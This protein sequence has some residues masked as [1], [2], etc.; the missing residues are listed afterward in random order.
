MSEDKSHDVHIHRST[1]AI[2]TRLRPTLDEMEDALLR[3]SSM[4]HRLG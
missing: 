3:E 1:G 2:V 4:E